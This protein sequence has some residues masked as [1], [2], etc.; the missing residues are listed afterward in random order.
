MADRF[1]GLLAEEQSMSTYAYP[2]E[3]RGSAE[4]PLPVEHMTDVCRFLPELATELATAQT[5]QD[6]EVEQKQQQLLHLKVK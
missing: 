3:S 4:A 1:H 5:S 2:S 6:V